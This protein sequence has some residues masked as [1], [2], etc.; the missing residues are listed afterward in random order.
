[1]MKQLGTPEDTWCPRLQ[2]VD[3]R[4]GTASAQ[5]AVGGRMGRWNGVDHTRTADCPRQHRTR[6][7]DPGHDRLPD[8]N[9]TAGTDDLLGQRLRDG[10]DIGAAAAVTDPSR[11]TEFDR[12]ALERDEQFNT[13]ISGYIGFEQAARN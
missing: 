6:R 13:R 2:P 11:M 1:M 4:H 12:V 3:D 5:P 7:V 9:F 8:W 10:Y